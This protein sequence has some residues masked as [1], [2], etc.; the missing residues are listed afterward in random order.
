[1]QIQC[2]SHDNDADAHAEVERLLAAGTPGARISVLT[3]RM[4]ADH[5]EESR[6][7]V[8]GH[9]RLRGRLRRLGGRR[10]PTTWAASPERGCSAAAASATPTATSSRR[11][12]TASAASTSPPTASWR[13]A[14]RAPGSSAEAAAAD[15][16]ALHAG[17]VLVVVSPA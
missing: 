6:R 7:D 8:R 3:G 13:S 17:R 10:P 2:S 12:P 5:R 1:M 15:V 9:R 4:P 14:S 16:A 11:T